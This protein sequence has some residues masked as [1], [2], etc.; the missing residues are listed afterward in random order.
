MADDGPVGVHCNIQ[1]SVVSQWSKGLFQDDEAVEEPE[2]YKPLTMISERKN[3]ENPT[4]KETGHSGRHCLWGRI[5]KSKKV[6][7]GPE[8]LLK[9]EKK[10]GQRRI[11]FW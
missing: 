1:L 5:K 8:S 3:G 9:L 4:T 7:E 10:W 11:K 2:L 6:Q